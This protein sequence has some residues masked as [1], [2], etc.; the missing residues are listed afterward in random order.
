MFFFFALLA[1]KTAVL[2][3]LRLVGLKDGVQKSEN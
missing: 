2:K 1:M 3:I